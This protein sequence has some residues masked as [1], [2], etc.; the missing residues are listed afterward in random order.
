MP[1]DL[2]L[3]LAD[4]GAETSELDRMLAGLVDAHWDLSTPAEGWAIRDQVSHLAYFDQAATLAATDPDRFRAEAA[5]L[6]ARGEDFPDRVAERY[7]ALPQ[8]AL[9]SW[10]R[11]ARNDFLSTFRSADPAARLPWYGPDM[12]A[13]SSVTARLMETWAHGQDV[14]DALGVRRQ[15]TERLRH[16]AHLGVRT[17]GF[18][19]RLHGRPAPALPVRVELA[20]P[21]GGTWTWG[22][23]DA[24]DT[25]RGPALD[26]CLAVTQRRNVADTALRATGPVAAEWLTIAQAFAGAPG[27]GRP[28]GRF[29]EVTP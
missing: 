12:S 28:P 24:T 19:F 23:P 15:P 17:L 20:A 13:A 1:A 29:A 18:S 25:V 21:G 14:A 26:F 16:I 22:P 11:R 3:L 2:H 10:F 7:R 5:E 6:M 4:L 9:L 8:D 27:T